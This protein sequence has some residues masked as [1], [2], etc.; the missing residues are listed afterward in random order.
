MQYFEKKI[1]NPNHPK[2]GK[3]ILDEKTRESKVER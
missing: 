1:L 3:Q 2:P